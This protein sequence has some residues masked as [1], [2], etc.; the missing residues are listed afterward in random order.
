M[1]YRKSATRDQS[2][3][4]RGSRNLK[5]TIIEINEEQTRI[6]ASAEEEEEK[7]Q[8]IYQDEEEEDALMSELEKSSSHTHTLITNEN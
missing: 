5:E 8:M 2:F 3:Y 6:N 4:S 1:Q 7:K